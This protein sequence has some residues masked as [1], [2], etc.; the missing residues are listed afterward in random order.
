VARAS[1]NRLSPRRRGV[2]A[3]LALLAGLAL[4]LALAAAGGL[5]EG[6]PEGISVPPGP[7][8]TGSIA[9]VAEF[10]PFAFEDGDPDD[11]LE[12]GRDGYAH[13]LYAFSPGGAG[14]SAARVA[15]YRSR[16][17]AAAER[18]DVEPDTLEALVMLESAGRPE[19]AAGDDPEGAVGLGQ[20]LPETATSLLGMSV[21]LEASKRLT[22]AIERQRRRARR[23]RSRQARRAAPTRIA[24]LARRRRAVDERYDSVRSLDGAARYLAIAERRL[25]REDLAVVSYHMGLGNLE[26][27]IEAYVAPARPRRTVRATVEAYEVSYA[28]LFYDSSPLQNRRAYSLLADFG[29]DS[30]S[31]LLR[32][33]AAREIMRLHRDDRTELSR[34]ERLHSLQPSGELVLR[35]PQETESL[36]DPETM[37]E[38]FGD[39][40]LVALPNDPER[41][42]FVL[43]PALGTLGAG[44]EAA[45]DPS[46]YRGLRP[47]AVAALL[48]ITK[49]VDRVAG[50]SG[51]RVTD[52]ARGEA[53]G[54]RLA[55][56][57]RARG[58]PPRPYSPHSTGFSFDIARVYPSPRVRRAFAY[59]LERLRAL[60]VI[61]YVYEPE[62]IHVTA[63]PDAERLLELQEALVPARG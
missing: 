32:V 3:A 6:R 15:R 18:H 56:A 48:Y 38:A 60:R 12:R 53:Y 8:G 24:R 58:E 39:G 47:E 63:G 35:P 49:E 28:R 59:V 9:D 62:E 26:Q 40:D 43:D 57:G 20:I 11:L 33:E 45:P 1:L 51:L 16:V 30:R 7:A 36:P 5:L 19:V 21:D 25:G 50:R 29:D 13:P 41:L 46:L 2:L 42:G 27:V 55:A 22:R 4:A 23:A 14:A 61:D 52:A 44:A 34:L 17:E 37:A 31:Y 10:E 54:R